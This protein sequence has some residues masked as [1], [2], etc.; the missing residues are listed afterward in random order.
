MILTC[1]SKTI[2]IEFGIFIIEVVIQ[3]IKTTFVFV[4]FTTITQ[5]GL[6]NFDNLLTKLLK[7]IPADSSITI[8]TTICIG[9]FFYTHTEIYSH[10]TISMDIYATYIGH[11]TVP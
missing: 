4:I 11:V 8:V 5:D 3:S 6:M 1:D 10:M 7:K 2:Y 9:S